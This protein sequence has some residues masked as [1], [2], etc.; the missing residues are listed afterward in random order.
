MTGLSVALVTDHLGT[1]GVTA[2][3]INPPVLMVPVGTVSEYGA[4]VP[5]TRA[6]NSGRQGGEG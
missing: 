6:G 1:A 3:R 5:L 2:I 4:P